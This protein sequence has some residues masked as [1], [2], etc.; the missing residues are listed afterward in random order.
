V[1]DTVTA[2]AKTVDVSLV[3]M[4]TG[5]QN[6][7]TGIGTNQQVSFV[8]GMIKLSNMSSAGSIRLVNAQGEIMI[9]QSFQ[10]SANVSVQVGR[11]LSIGNYVLSV[12]QENGVIQKMIVVR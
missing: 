5:I 11:N 3:R 10:P 6:N 2:I 12:T 7:R 1:T 9:M 4:T 8:N